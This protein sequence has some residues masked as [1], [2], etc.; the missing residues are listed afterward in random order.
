MKFFIPFMA[1]FQRLRFLSEACFCLHFRVCLIIILLTVPYSRVWSQSSYTKFIKKDVRVLNISVDQLGTSVELLDSVVPSYSFF[2]S[3]E[4]HWKSVNYRVQFRLLTYLYHHS[5]VRNL[6]LEGGYTYG[7]MINRYLDSGD[8]RLLIK[9]IYDTPV[10]PEDLRSF[11]KKIY[12]FNQSLPEG[13]KIRVMGIDVEQSPLLVLECLYFMLPDRTL[14]AGVRDKIN[15]LKDLYG[16]EYDEKEVKKFFR[17][18]HKEVMERRRA[19]KRFWGDQFWLFKLILENTIQG[20]DSP[21][22]REFVYAHGDEKKREER[23]FK[24]FRLLYNNSQFLPGNY[25]GQFGAIHTELNPS[26]NWGYLTLARNLNEGK[27][28][29]VKGQVLTISKFFRRLNM[30]YEKFPEYG[31]FMKIMAAVDKQMD[32]DVVL[33]KLLGNEHLFP[34]ISKDFQYILI[35]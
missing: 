19:Y 5:D 12:E 22:L 2:F 3:A 11:F 15:Q 4:E 17:Q 24:N 27:Y 8:E 1:F 25:Y 26:I 30:I 14:T 23:M 32:D 6:I 18:F 33:C 28:S 10:C 7:H 9:A 13:Q 35:S 29:P 34:E 21:L 20:F 31:R 16:Q